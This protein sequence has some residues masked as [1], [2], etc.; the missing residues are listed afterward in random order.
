VI[1]A[2][3]EAK[4]A[5]ADNRRYQAAGSL[6]VSESQLDLAAPRARAAQAQVTAAHNKELATEAQAAL[7]K[8]LI[9]T[10]SAEVQNKE[11]MVRQAELNL[12]YTEVKAPEAGYV[13][14][15]T[16]EAGAYVQK[17]QP[18]LAIVQS[19][20]W[21][22]ATFKETQLTRMRPG[23]P[24]KVKVDA[25]PRITFRGRVTSPGALAFFGVTCSRRWCY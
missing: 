13:T 6:A 23:Q 4:R 24:V 22:V 1:A 18:L 8:A 10:A 17:G 14:H 5:E 21:V 11:A 3:A 7:D 25:Y 15:R 16:V 2:E 19:K 9:Q 20:V 12:S